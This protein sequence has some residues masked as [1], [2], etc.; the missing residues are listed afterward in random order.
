MISDEYNILNE[1]LKEDFGEALEEGLL[2]LFNACCGGNIWVI[3]YSDT[4]VSNTY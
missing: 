1:Q 4:S 2:A 3:S